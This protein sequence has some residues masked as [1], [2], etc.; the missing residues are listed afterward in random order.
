M[1][2]FRGFA[3]RFA[4]AAAL[5]SGCAV[6]ASASG[7]G[8]SVFAIDS[9]FYNALGRGSDYDG[10]LVPSAKYNYSTGAIDDAPLGGVHVHRKNYFTFD[11]SGI[12][13][14]ITGAE[15]RLYN[16][17]PIPDGG[18]GYSSP[19]PSEMY[20]VGGSMFATTA[21]MADFAA[22]LTVVNDPFT[23]PGAAAGIALYGKIADTLDGMPPF[24]MKPVDVTTNGTMVVVPLTDPGVLPYLNF[25]KG[26][27]V[28][29]GG[30]L[31]DLNPGPPDEVMFGYTHPLFPPFPSPTPELF[32]TVVPEPGTLAALGL[33][34]ICL[35]RRRKRV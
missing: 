34:A 32:L 20:L 9:G 35:L 29:L 11:L 2:F 3:A 8:V 7:I 10:T 13:D 4:C 12:T 17:A 33:G 30:K 31:M 24:G 27:P 14:E 21:E 28:V 1:R 16:A 26:G 6:I 22:K 5:T 15:L 25:F 23:A 18:L 19:D